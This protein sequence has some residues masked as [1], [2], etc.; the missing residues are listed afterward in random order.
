[1]SLLNSIAPVGADPYRAN[2]CEACEKPPADPNASGMK[3]GQ[4]NRGPNGF[5]LGIDGP[6]PNLRAGGTHDQQEAQRDTM[7]ALA[8]LALGS[9]TTGHTPA[10][11]RVPTDSQVEG[12][13]AGLKPNPPIGTDGVDVTHAVYQSH[14]PNATTAEAYKH[15]V[16][17][18]DQVFSAGGMEIRPPAARL[19][20]GGR[21][22][23]EIGTPVPT[24]LPIEVRLDPQN[25]AITINTLDGHVL[26]G[27]QTFTFTDDCKGGVTLTQDAHFQAS[28][29]LPEELQQLTSIS[30][31]QHSTWE[32]AHREIYGEFNGDR[33]YQG[34]GTRVFN[35]QQLGAWAEALGK[36]VSDPGHAADVGIDAAG[37]LANWGIDLHGKIIAKAFDALHIPGGKLIENAYD[38][39]GD[40]TSRAADAAGNFAEAAIDFINPFG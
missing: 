20:D 16:E 33:N 40:L 11:P 9:Y 15:F 14:I 3:Q 18:P 23:L 8:A 5:D 37:E 38:K 26:R 2:Y 1:M 35:K 6:D 13:L 12:I 31:G 19:E 30:G 22:M 29:R 25:H 28:S 27:E 4:V 32:N 10:T 34:I 39:L 7:V 21:Y 17:H 24:W 36:V